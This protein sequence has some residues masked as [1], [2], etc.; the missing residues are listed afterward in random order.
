MREW[1]RAAA[2]RLCSLEGG[3]STVAVGGAGSDEVGSRLGSMVIS[4]VAQEDMTCDAALLLART[5]DLQSRTR[6][7]Q[8]K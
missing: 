6:F 1:A 2:E 4:R 5:Q 3:E 8:T 7:A